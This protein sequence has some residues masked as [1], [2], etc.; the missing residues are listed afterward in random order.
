[1]ETLAA[2]TDWAANTDVTVNSNDFV[3]SISVGEVAIWCMGGI[4][5][6]VQILK[7]GEKSN[8]KLGYALVRQYTVAKGGNRRLFGREEW[9]KLADLDML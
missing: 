1:M 5:Y 8:G 6:P 9:A 3:S 7:F 2:N 4:P